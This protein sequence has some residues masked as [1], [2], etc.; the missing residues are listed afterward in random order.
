M[1]RMNTIIKYNLESYVLDLVRQGLSSREIASKI[2]VDHNREISHN[3]V[4]RFTKEIREE[5]AEVSK[6]VVQEHIQKT[7]PTDLQDLDDVLSVFKDSLPKKGDEIKPKHLQ[8]YYAWI[9]GFELKLKYSG[10]GESN[11]DPNDMVTRDELDELLD[12]E[13]DDDE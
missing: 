10:A 1:P 7:V 12:E 3:A 6:A 5:R 4:H 11:N 9:K 2:K 13:D 8:F